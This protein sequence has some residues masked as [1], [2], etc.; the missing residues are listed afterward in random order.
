MLLEKFKG[1]KVG[2]IGVGGTGSYILDFLSKTPVLEIHIFDTDY[3]HNKNAFRA[4]GGTHIDSL[5]TPKRKVDYFAEEYSKIHQ[6]IK[7]HPYNIKESN[8]NLLN[9]LSF[10]FISIDKSQAKK[11]IIEHLVEQGIDFIDVGM[12]VHL[13]NGAIMGQ[14]RTTTSTTESRNQI[15]DK[16][17]IKLSNNNNNDYSNLVQIAELNALNAAFAVLKWKKLVGFYHDR[18]EEHHSMYQIHINKNLNFDKKP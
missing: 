2:I 5:T 3:Y 18:E 4:P 8:L 6:G 14:L 11:L 13:I 7:R 16:N 10:V 1:M 15:A 12:G 17:R 9:G